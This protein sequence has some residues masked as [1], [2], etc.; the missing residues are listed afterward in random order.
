MWMS[1]LKITAEWQKWNKYNDTAHCEWVS[2]KLQQSDKNVIN[3]LHYL[4][5]AFT[6]SRSLS[7]KATLLIRPDFKCTEIVRYY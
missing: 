6:C 2:E 3:W 4:M 7:Y 1:I 5:F